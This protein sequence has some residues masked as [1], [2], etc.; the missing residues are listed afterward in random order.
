MKKIVN[1]LLGCMITSIGVIIL[2]HS[3]IVTGGTAGLSLSI[4]YLITLPFALIFFLVNIPF[5]I[6]SVMRM[7]WKFT[8]NTIFSVSVLTLMT[9]V[10]HFLPAFTIPILVGSILGGVLIGIGLSIVFMN[11]SS[12]GGANIL[13]LFLQKRFG[14]NPGTINFLFDF[15][16]VMS[17]FLTIGWLKGLC[18]ILSIA[19]TSRIIGY[20]K[21]EIANR[22]AVT[23]KK[24]V[25]SYKSLKSEV[26]VS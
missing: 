8:L 14:T 5:Y 6:F 4:S 2:Q 17:C 18:S 21:N 10:D 26:S 23:S 16:V 22:N 24:E 12:L 25:S 3:N 1:I 11:G 15:I 7:G 20:F 19:I 9:S 13:A